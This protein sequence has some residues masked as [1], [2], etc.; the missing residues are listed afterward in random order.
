MALGCG[1][2]RAARRPREPGAVLAAACPPGVRSCALTC[3]RSDSGGSSRRHPRWCRCPVADWP[4]SFEKVVAVVELPR[5][6]TNRAWRTEQF[7]ERF[8]RCAIQTAASG[9][10][11]GGNRLLPTEKVCQTFFGGSL[12][13]RHENLPL[14]KKSRLLGN[15][16]NKRIVTGRW[17]RD[18][19]AV[20]TMGRASAHGGIAEQWRFTAS[21]RAASRTRCPCRASFTLFFTSAS[22]S[23][24]HL[25]PP[26]VSS[27]V[28]IK[29][30]YLFHQ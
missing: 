23:F 18:G 17:L 25:Q 4:A 14:R 6:R 30:G 7:A 10:W 15:A 8:P 16:R 27:A 13:P 24:R 21:D 29:C 1:A 5:R 26:C 11:D 12:L 19:T 9:D 28:F 2:A 20:E 3:R 22:G